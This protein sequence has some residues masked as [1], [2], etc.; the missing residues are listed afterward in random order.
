VRTR[1]N[2][3]AERKC[4]DMFSRSKKILAVMVMMAVMLETPLFMPIFGGGGG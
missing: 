4:R 1:A 3:R 2:R